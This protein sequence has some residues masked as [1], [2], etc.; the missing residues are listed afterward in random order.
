MILSSFTALALEFL[1]PHSDNLYLNLHLNLQ[2]QVCTCDRGSGGSGINIF[3]TINVSVVGK[4]MRREA[5]CK[6]ELLLYN[7][8][9]DSGRPVG[10]SVPR[11]QG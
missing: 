5:A 7:I 6:P 1:L 9:L 3:S 8:S 4:S 2:L 11:C 10:L